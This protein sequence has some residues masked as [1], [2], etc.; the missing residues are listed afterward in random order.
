[1]LKPPVPISPVAW[2]L[3]EVVASALIVRWAWRQLKKLP[4]IVILVALAGYVYLS[5][6]GAATWWHRF[7]AREGPVIAKELRVYAART[8]DALLSLQRSAPPSPTA[9]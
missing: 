7:S 2:W 8:E 4:A 3:L 6:P 9:R 5:V 1:M